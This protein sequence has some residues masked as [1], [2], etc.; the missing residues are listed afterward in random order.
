MSVRGAGGPANQGRSRAATPC[1]CA[2]ASFN[3]LLPLATSLL[4]Y[5]AQIVCRY[6]TLRIDTA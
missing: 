6:S 4:S 3:N 1:T 5:K 2:S